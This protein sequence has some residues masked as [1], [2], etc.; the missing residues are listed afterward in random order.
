MSSFLNLTREVERWIDQR[1]LLSE[2]ASA[3]LGLC[4]FFVG[5]LLGLAELIFLS[6]KLWLK[7]VGVLVICYLT[8]QMFDVRDDINLSWK[9]LTGDGK[10]SQLFLLIL[11]AGLLCLLLGYGVVSVMPG[12]LSLWIDSQILKGILW[13]S[14]LFGFATLAFFGSFWCW[15][16]M[17]KLSTRN[18][19]H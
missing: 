5:G 11:T 17:L 3:V 9:F 10:A 12:I 4:V 2:Y 15:T 19:P 18:A 1:F 16:V 6:E 7:G 14:C 13:V 8:R